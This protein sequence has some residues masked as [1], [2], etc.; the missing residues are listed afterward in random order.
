MCE[1]VWVDEEFRCLVYIC[2][3]ITKIN[4]RSDEGVV[5]EGVCGAGP[6]GI[7]WWRGGAWCE[8]N[9]SQLHDNAT[10]DGGR[11]GGR[12]LYIGIIKMPP[13]PGPWTTRVKRINQPGDMIFPATNSPLYAVQ[14]LV[15]PEGIVK[16]DRQMALLYVIGCNNTTGPPQ[17]KHYIIRH[18]QY[19]ICRG[20]Y[21][22]YL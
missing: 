15:S 11:R 10:I 12:A 3:L 19:Y 14:L 13:P 1:C 2:Y 4:K 8:G 9:R 20:T 16:S 6:G 17:P 5:A 18:I 21:T 22:Y 7:T